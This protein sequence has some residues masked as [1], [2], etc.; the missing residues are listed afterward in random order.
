MPR[1]TALP[2]NALFKI[3]A[4]SKATP[5]V[6]VIDKTTHIMLFSKAV[7]KIGSFVNKFI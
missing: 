5:I 4:N 7:G 2:L 1:N 6:S 3:S